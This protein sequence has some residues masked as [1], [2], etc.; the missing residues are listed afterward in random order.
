MSQYRQ[1]ILQTAVRMDAMFL[2]EALTDEKLAAMGQESYENTMEQICNSIFE[3]KEKEAIDTRI[4]TRGLAQVL[5]SLVQGL[6]T[7][8]LFS[9]DEKIDID[10]YHDAAIALLTRDIF[11]EDDGNNNK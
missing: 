7:Q 10:K 11:T 8:I 6:S 9:G 4:D 5:F 3:A 2:A 1:P